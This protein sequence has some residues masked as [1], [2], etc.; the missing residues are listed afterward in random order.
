M[1]G[2]CYK[3]TGFKVGTLWG[4]LASHFQTALQYTL[5]AVLACTYALHTSIVRAVNVLMELS[6][7]KLIYS[8][9]PLFKQYFHLSFLQAV[10]ESQYHLGKFD[11]DERDCRFLKI[12]YSPLCLFSVFFASCFFLSCSLTLSRG[13]PAEA[14]RVAYQFGESPFRC[15]SRL[16][17]GHSLSTDI[18]IV[19]E[20][21]TGPGRMRAGPGRTIL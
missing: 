1:T 10:L 3:Y 14:G 13:G 20:V 11:K 5:Q 7:P 21:S 4:G 16:L 12:Y 19:L 2:I 6:Y 9:I 15:L 17:R 8:Y 18:C